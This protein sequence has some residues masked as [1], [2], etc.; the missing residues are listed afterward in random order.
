M[1]KDFRREYLE[2][3]PQESVPD[4]VRIIHMSQMAVNDVAYFDNNEYLIS[5]H[6]IAG[7]QMRSIFYSH[8]RGREYD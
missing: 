5:R 7:S 8:I 6:E 3:S 1:R 2:P 4:F